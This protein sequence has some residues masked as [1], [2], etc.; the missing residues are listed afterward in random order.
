[1][2]TFTP[3]M[4][5]GLSHRPPA[6]CWYRPC[7][8]YGPLLP[9]PFLSLFSQP[10]GPHLAILFTLP[11]GPKFL[12]VRPRDHGSPG[13]CSFPQDQLPF[14]CPLNRSFFSMARWVSLSLVW[15]WR[16]PALHAGGLSFDI[17]FPGQRRFSIRTLTVPSRIR[18]NL[19]W[20]MS[21]GVPGVVTI[22]GAALG[23]ARFFDQEFLWVGGPSTNVIND[24]HQAFTLSF[25]LDTSGRN[26]SGHLDTD[27]GW[28]GLTR[29]ALASPERVVL[30]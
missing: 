29:R 30:L 15:R 19:I 16:L 2:I 13:L 5:P 27:S 23:R 24:S 12:L 4:W 6:R 22:M 8:P 11:V 9:C 26:V 28:T 25:F 17:V 1:M 20:T 10:P 3:R 21:R 14:Y 7:W 18:E